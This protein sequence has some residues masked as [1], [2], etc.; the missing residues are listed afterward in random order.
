MTFFC[1]EA[2]H[3]LVMEGGCACGWLRRKFGGNPG[4]EPAQCWFLVGSSPAA[5]THAIATGVD[6]PGLGAA[7]EPE[8]PIVATWSLTLSA[9]SAYSSI[10]HPRLSVSTSSL[11]IKP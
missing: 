5:P 8:E 11:P 7:L 2:S 9:S 1:P 3:P 4:M 6:E 10:W